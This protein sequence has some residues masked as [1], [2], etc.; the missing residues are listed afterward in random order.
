LALLYSLLPWKRASHFGVITGNL[1]AVS[2]S[3]DQTTSHTIISIMPSYARY[4][5]KDSH[6]AV[7]DWARSQKSAPASIEAYEFKSP[8]D[9]HVNVKEVLFGLQM[10]MMSITDDKPN[11]L[12]K[13]GQMNP[14]QIQSVKLIVGEDQCHEPLT[15]LLKTHFQLTLDQHIDHGG[16][17]KAGHALDTQ[18]FIAHNDTTVVLAYRCTTSASDWLTNL[19]TT[20][21]AFE[22]EDDHLQGHSGF[23]SCFDCCL[24]NTKSNLPL[25][26]TGFYNN[27]LSS[28]VDIKKYLDPLVLGED[29]K[30]RTLYISGHSLVRG[31]VEVNEYFDWDTLH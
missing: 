13:V 23:L 26:H 12:K 31:F 10:A 2:I 24:F 28:V 3:L 18:G 8:T 14:W 11:T 16:L 7:L 19:T 25:V 17:T 20:T 6:P 22:P 21:S 4:V 29:G 1:L 15:K 30:E 5:L 9:P 27:F